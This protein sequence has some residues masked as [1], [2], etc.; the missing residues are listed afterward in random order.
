MVRAPATTIP[1]HIIT[2][3]TIM[4]AIRTTVPFIMV[5]GGNQPYKTLAEYVDAAKKEKLTYG[6]GGVAGAP[7]IAAE[8]LPKHAFDVRLIVNDENVGAHL[9]SPGISAPRSCVA[10]RRLMPRFAALF[11]APSFA[12]L[13][14]TPCER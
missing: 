4:T 7:Q 13:L 14:S 8:M 2:I 10:S 12:R 1:P 3:M 5:V 6:H 9:V 11:G